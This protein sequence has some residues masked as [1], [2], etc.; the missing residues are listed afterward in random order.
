MASTMDRPSVHPIASDYGDEDKY[1]IKAAMVA[2]GYGWPNGDDPYMGIVLNPWD[3][4]YEMQQ[5]HIAAAVEEAAAA[6]E[7]AEDERWRRALAV[8]FP[9]RPLDPVK[10]E[11]D[12][13]A[14]DEE[15][16]E[17]DGYVFQ[18]YRDLYRDEEAET[19]DANP[20]RPYSWQNGGAPVVGGF[21][22]VGAYG[23]EDGEDVYMGLL[24]WPGEDGYEEQ[25]AA[26]A[27]GAAAKAAAAAGGGG[28]GGGKDKKD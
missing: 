25:Q 19:E 28:C 14:E 7:A 1:G 16:E 9:T 26:I 4:G 12:E 22:A 23:W 15:A 5:A 24:L 20:F 8:Y 10:E 3:W 6:E 21:G 27:A 2:L 11:E 18:R 13:E 17:D